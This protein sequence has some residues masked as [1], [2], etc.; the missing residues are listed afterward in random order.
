MPQEPRPHGRIVELANFGS[1]FEADAAIS[2][3]TS[4]GIQATA[5]YGDAGGWAPHFALVDGFRV[6]VF[7]DE[8]DLARA[9][10]EAEQ[11]LE[12]SPD[13]EQPEPG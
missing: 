7:D 1:R 9:L 3:L 8:L 4:S 5:K 11:I 2:L 10:L 12:A 13:A 6:L